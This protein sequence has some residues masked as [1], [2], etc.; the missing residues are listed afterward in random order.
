MGVG[1]ETR[2]KEGK[3]RHLGRQ[4]LRR[5]RAKKEFKGKEVAVNR[6]VRG[7]GRT[8]RKKDEVREKRNK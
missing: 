6:K 3:M 7:Q 8:Y 5:M 4:R 2:K 1:E